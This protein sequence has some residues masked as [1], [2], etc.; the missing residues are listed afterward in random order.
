MYFGL[1]MTLT[2]TN[3]PGIFTEKVFH[4]KK[5]RGCKGETRGC[6]KAKIGPTTRPNFLA[7]WWGPLSPSSVTSSPSFYKI[8]ISWKT[9]RPIFYV[10]FETSVEASPLLLRKRAGPVAV[11]PPPRGIQHRHRHWHSLVMGRG[12]N[13]SMYRNSA[14]IIPYQIDVIP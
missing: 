12:T 13:F 8:S 5:H 11:R 9:V 6:P 1:P 3:G 14:I 2:E 7:T 4:Q 10:I